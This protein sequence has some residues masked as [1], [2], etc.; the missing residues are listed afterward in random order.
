MTPFEDDDS[1]TSISG[2]SVENGRGGI[3]IS[4]DLRIGRDQT[5]LRRARELKRV[6]DAIAARLETAG[7]LPVTT[8]DDAKPSD[9]VANPFT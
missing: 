3:S 7:D 8:A 1:S 4:G 6:V 2:L 5:G 9:D